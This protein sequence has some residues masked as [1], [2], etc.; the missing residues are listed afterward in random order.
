MHLFERDCTAQRRHQKVVERAPAV[1]LSEAQRAE[2]CAAA[3]AICRE[4][5]YTSAG[6]VEFL[7]DADTGLCYFI[8][9]N[10]RI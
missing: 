4:A 1:F 6:T 3:L 10:P 2:L 9:V 8:E 7:Q 5:R